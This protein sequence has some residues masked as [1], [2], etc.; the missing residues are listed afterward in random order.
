MRRLEEASTH[1]TLTDIKRPQAIAVFSTCSSKLAPVKGS[2]LGGAQGPKLHRSV[3]GGYTLRHIL[4][5][6]AC[7]LL[8]GCMV[9]DRPGFDDVRIAPPEAAEEQL[10]SFRPQLLVDGDTEWLGAEAL[11]D[12]LFRIKVM[13][14]DSMDAKFVLDG[15]EGEV[16]DASTD[17]LLR[18]ADEARLLY[19][20]DV[21]P[22]T[23]PLPWT[24]RRSPLLW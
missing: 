4:V 23:P 3:Q 16:K 10:R 15:R 7:F 1:M 21:A 6:H 13:Y 18:V 17:L 2:S 22:P 5:P 11:A 19:S 8:G 24:G 20:E 9:G 12:V 14:S